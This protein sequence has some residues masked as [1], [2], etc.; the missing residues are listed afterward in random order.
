MIT[1]RAI[2]RRQ[3]R[4]LPRAFAVALL[5]LF[6]FTTLPVSGE[7]HEEWLQ[8]GRIIRPSEDSPAKANALCLLGNHPACGWSRSDFGSAVALDGAALAVAEANAERVHI[9]E[10][11]PIGWVHAATFPG[12]SGFS[13]ALAVEGTTVVTG[14]PGTSELHVFQKI[15]GSW[16]E[17]VSLSAA[18][19]E[20]M[21]YTVAIRAGQIVAGDPCVSKLYV[22][23][24]AEEGWAHTATLEVP[25]AA[26]LGVL[27][28]HGGTHIVAQTRPS[29]I[30]SFEETENGW[31]ATLVTT[32]STGHALGAEG[33]TV[34][35]RSG[36]EI[37]L[38]ER[39]RGQWTESARLRPSDAS[40]FVGHE[41]FGWSLALG[42]GILAVGAPLDDLSSGDAAVENFAKD[43]CAS[44]IGIRICV[45]PRPGGVYI[46]ERIGDVWERS[47]KITGDLVGEH[48]FGHAVALD[49]TDQRIA[50]GAPFKLVSTFATQLDV[51]PEDSV[52]LYERFRGER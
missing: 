33:N 43:A 50:V 15:D 3:R 16:K 40:P 30:Y 26:W 37:L 39:V 29:A 31:T 7:A 2:P 12:P 24:P 20:C 11:G 17:L 23:D 48:R 13:P 27:L 18:G 22:Y 6:A 1:N 52:Y 9:Y 44:Q 49:E 41:E 14:T 21:G 47:A 34:A 46:F 5:L 51:D 32:A 35:V 10:E 19:S 45:P 36:S 28:A 25:G 38:I 42:E 4:V 8:S